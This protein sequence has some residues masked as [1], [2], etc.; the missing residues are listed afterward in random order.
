MTLSINARFFSEKY[1]DQVN[2]VMTRTHIVFLKYL[3]WLNTLKLHL[4]VEKE[5][6][7]S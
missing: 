7:G 3:E 4:K 6:L 2:C 1:P 5:V